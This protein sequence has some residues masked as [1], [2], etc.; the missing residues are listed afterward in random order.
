MLPPTEPLNISTKKV[1]QP[2]APILLQFVGDNVSATD[3]M[4]K[5]GIDYFRSH[6]GIAFIPCAIAVSGCVA[7][8]SGITAFRR[9]RTQ[10]LMKDDIS[11]A[12][13]EAFL[14]NAKE[15]HQKKISSPNNLTNNLP[16][17]EM[18][19]KQKEAAI[20]EALGKAPNASDFFTPFDIAKL[21]L[22]PATVI[23]TEFFIFWKLTQHYTGIQNLNEALEYGRWYAGS[24]PVPLRLRERFELKKS[25]NGMPVELPDNVEIKS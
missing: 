5:K 19:P 11:T 21:F 25:K 10:L 4:F 22:W 20:R 14:K 2:E 9:K 17:I 13:E 16:A 15:A 6:L 8:F 18:S 3:D 12:F 23:S 1:S 24:G 7:I